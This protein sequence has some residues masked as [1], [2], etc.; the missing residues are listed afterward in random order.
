LVPFNDLKDVDEKSL[1]T[2][3]DFK[4][5]EEFDRIV[6][7]RGEK[8]DGQSE[9]KWFWRDEDMAG[10]IAEN[11][12]PAPDPRT[13]E[14]PPRREEIQSPKESKSFWGRRKSSKSTADVP[15]V[16][17]P[18]RSEKGES[19]R[20]ENKDKVVMTIKAEEIV[21][22]TES[23]FGILGTERGW[24]IVVRMKVHLFRN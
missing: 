9:E 12:K 1:P 8:S 16:Q 20:V 4:N 14:L 6:R 22:R 7:V 3:F 18:E 24:G 23:A 19:S 5:P 17:E 10:R 15:A 2:D 11:L 13:M 21:F